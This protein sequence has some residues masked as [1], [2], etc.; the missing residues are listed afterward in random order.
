MAMPHFL[1]CHS[2]LSQHYSVNAAAC[3]VCDLHPRKHVTSALINLHW[4]PV[5]AHIEL[6]ICVI[7][8]QLL[9]NSNALAYISNNAAASLHTSTSD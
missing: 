4:L 7:A 1:D 9:K 2:P 5:A 6:K 8:Y 3:L